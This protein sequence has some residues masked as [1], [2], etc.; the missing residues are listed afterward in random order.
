MSRS[1]Y[2]DDMEDQWQHIMWRGTI[3]SATRGKRGQAFFRDLLAALDA[4]PEKKL[5]PNEL[6][7]R[8]GCVCALGALGKAR[9]VDLHEVDPEDSE[10]VAGIFNIADPLAREVVWVNDEAGAWKETPEA[11]FIRVRAWASRQ[12]KT[13]PFPSISSQPIQEG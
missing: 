13:D 4:L 11:R 8:D 9:G 6:E 5:I 2:C 1:G 12:I 7:T 10:R 3:A